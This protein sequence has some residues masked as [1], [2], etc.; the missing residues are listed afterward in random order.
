LIPGFLFLFLDFYNNCQKCVPIDLANLSKVIASEAK[1][2]LRV[3]KRLLR[4][5]APRNDRLSERRFDN[6]YS[7]W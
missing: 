3:S 1:Q 5:L 2:S 6:R 4:R 7:L